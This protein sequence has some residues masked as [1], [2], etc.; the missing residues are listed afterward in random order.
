ML[1]NSMGAFPQPLHLGFQLLKKS[2]KQEHLRNY[3]HQHEV[4]RTQQDSSH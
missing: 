2:L 1:A 3:Q 4:I